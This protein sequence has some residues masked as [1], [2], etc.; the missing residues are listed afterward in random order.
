MCKT[1]KLGLHNSVD[2]D[3]I[4]Q[5]Q[6]RRWTMAAFV[7]RNQN[8]TGT[9]SASPFETPFKRSG[10]VVRII[11]AAECFRTYGTDRSS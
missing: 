10:V 1:L 9:Q 8:S 11:T 6:T 7:T 4:N 3:K 5:V 2:P